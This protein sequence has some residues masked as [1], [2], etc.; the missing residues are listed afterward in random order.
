M[1][2]TLWYSGKGKT[3]ETVKWLVV[4]RGGGRHEGRRECVEHRGLLKAVTPLCMML[5]WEHPVLNNGYRSSYTWPSPYKVQYQERT[6][7]KLQTL[8]G[9]DGV[10]AGSQTVTSVPCWG[11][12][13][14]NNGSCLS[15]GAGRTRE[16][17]AFSSVLLWTWHC[18]KK[19]KS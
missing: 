12:G 11:V 15:V 2:L 13:V 10:S 7:V 9:Y 17:S 19:I 6:V 18:S 16:I 4:A 3:M 1:F 14:D 5:W 8:G